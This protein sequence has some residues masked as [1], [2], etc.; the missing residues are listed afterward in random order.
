[1]RYVSTRGGGRSVPSASAILEGIA[2]DGGLF[3]PEKGV[4]LDPRRLVGKDYR[5]IA[6]E[7]LHSF[8]DD[9]SREELTSCLTE[10]YA[11]SK[12]DSAD[13]APLR[14]IDD[15]TSVLELWHGPTSAFKDMALQVLPRLVALAREKTGSEKELVILVATSGDTGTAALD[16]FR[17]VPGTRVIVFY[18]ESGVSEVQRLQ[19]ITQ[20]GSNVHAIGIRGGDFDDAQAGVK[21]IF[22]DA[23]FRAR[24]AASGRE[25]SSANS[26]NWGRLVPQIAYYYAGYL[27][28][29]ADNRI[30]IGQR[31]DVAVPTGNFGDIL[32]AYYA[33]GMG[34]PLGRLVCASNANDVLTRFLADGRYDR[35]RKLRKTMSPSMDIVVS[36]NLER[37]LHDLS[38]RD[39]R[40][41]AAWMDSLAKEGHYAIDDIMRNKI[42]TVFWGAS[43]SEEETLATIAET[44]RKRRYLVDTHTAVALNVYEKYRAAAHAAAGA[45]I[46]RGRVD[47]SVGPAW[48]S[49]ATAFAD[50]GSY[51]LVASTASPFKFNASVARAILGDDACAGRGEFELLDTLSEVCHAAVPPGIASLRGKPILHPGTC[52]VEGMRDEVAAILGLGGTR[53]RV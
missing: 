14:H 36:S 20:A 26:I 25:L 52:S 45:G 33:R 4:S 30:E 5:G 7:T 2:S 23:D 22:A 10:A 29:V 24:L 12:F 34:L 50:G 18:P 41:V 28:L 8:L 49:R 40:R 46:G 1:M 16:G 15:G 27:R 32:A 48:N 17:D 51:V 42:G 39:G 31:V 43:C 6:L 9:Y 47:A 53:T 3:V 11:S 35:R 21:A 13:I 44:W 19:M 38:D 37:L